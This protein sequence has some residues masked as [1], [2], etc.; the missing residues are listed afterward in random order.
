MA[1]LFPLFEPSDTLVRDC[2]IV[3]AIGV[4]YKLLFIVLFLSRTANASRAL[5]AETFGRPV[6]AVPSSEL[7]AAGPAPA[8]KDAV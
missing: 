2:L 8:G 1:K 6:L 3:F 5:P 7:T 4:V